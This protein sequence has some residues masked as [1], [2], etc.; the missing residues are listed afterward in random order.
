MRKKDKKKLTKRKIILSTIGAVLVIF[1][2]LLGINIFLQPK[3]S[4]SL[5]TLK[6]SPALVL[7]GK[8]NVTS[9][10]PVQV[11]SEGQYQDTVVSDGQRVYQG[12]TVMEY[13]DNT[14]QAEILQQQNE[15]AATQEKINNINRQLSQLRQQGND[16]EAA[17]QVTELQNSLVDANT[18]LKNGQVKLAALQAQTAQQIKAPA[19]GIIHVVDGE[20]GVPKLYVLSDQKII[21]TKV[22]EYDQD[23]VH[24]G[25]LCNITSDVTNKQLSGQVLAISSLPESLD[26]VNNTGQRVSYYPVQIESAIKEKVGTDVHIKFP[27]KGIP[28]PQSALFTQKGKAYVYVYQHGTA[29]KTRIWTQTVGGS[30]YVKAGVKQGQKIVIDPSTKMRLRSMLIELKNINKKFALGE[31][32]FQALRE[33]SLAIATGEYVSIMGTSGAG[34]TTLID[35]IGFLD[36]DY[37][38]SYTFNGRDV[39]QMTENQAA[40]LRNT[41]VGFVFQNF[42]LIPNLSV[43]ENV[44][45]PLLYAGKRR[46]ETRPIVE[47]ALASVG[48]A[49][50][51][52]KL[53]NQLSGGQQQ[54]V[55]I[56]R[57]I[58]NEPDFIIADEPTGAL[59]S[60]TSIEIMKIFQSLHRQ[61]KTLLI[62]THDPKVG[63]QAQRMIRLEDGQI[64]MDGRESNDS[65]RTD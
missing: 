7:Q 39:S 42:K 14:K 11:N 43:F 38:G 64:V 8:V 44:E 21:K 52:A 57:A 30:T 53:P 13:S 41:H 62:V 24:D 58:I 55:S 26:N 22:S 6:Q 33:I 49:N 54:R 23:K 46:G 25:Q 12:Q 27:Q 4:Y 40:Q 19:D 32:N 51:G 61:G 20:D 9:Q 28:L 34:K 3:E 37:T 29:K 60:G 18:E 17:S 10:I 63:Q 1:L 5:Y 59:D 16:A 36:R 56:A 15:N 65:P 50:T 31:K 2:V 48:L 45:L 35:I 47:E